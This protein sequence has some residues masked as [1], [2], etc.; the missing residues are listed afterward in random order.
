MDPEER[1]AYMVE[2]K[3]EARRKER[4]ARI[5][6]KQVCATSTT[7]STQHTAHTHSHTL[8]HNSPAHDTTMANNSWRPMAVASQLL[9]LA[10]V[11]VDEEGVGDEAEVE[12]GSPSTE[13]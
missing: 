10:S 12:A 8:C 2:K 6:N 4:Q 3:K 1:Q 11:G 5:L 9:T 13:L 7:S